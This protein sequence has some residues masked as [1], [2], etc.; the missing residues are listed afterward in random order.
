MEPKIIIE[1]GAIK[2]IPQKVRGF[3]ASFAIITDGHLKKRGEELLQNMRA[4]GLKCNLLVLPPGENTKSM[5]FV[6]SLTG[7]LLK[8]GIRRDSCLI[9]LG[10][11]VIGD[12]TGFIASIFMRGIRFVAV[13][14]T[15]LGMVDACIGGKTGVD[16]KEGKNL[17]GTF[18]DPA[19]VIVDP[20][21]L[22]SLPER[23]FKCGMAEVIKHAII[24]DRKFFLFLEKNVGAILKRKPEIIKKLIAKNIEIKLKIV[25]KDKHENVHGYDKE[26]SRM[27][28]NYGHTV[29][30]AIEQ[31]SRYLVPHGEAI[32]MGMVAENRIAQAKKMMKESEAER[33]INLLK[34]FRLPVSIPADFTTAQIKKALVNDKKHVE[35]KL[36]FALPVGIG[37][38][39][40]VQI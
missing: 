38:A 18:Y 13:P 34:R 23:D 37:K 29:G 22:A 25:E 9:A 14:T 35:G 5:H 27:F 16:L 33:V 28:L 21:M 7:S 30:H 24:A 1:K 39:K 11:G 31:L 17:I 20:D 26:H 8:L 6:E 2:K 36:C 19:A 4:A 40:V 12:L 10:G 15:L 3:G 32:A